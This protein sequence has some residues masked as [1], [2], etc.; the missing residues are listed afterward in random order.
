M[1]RFTRNL[2]KYP[3]ALRD[4][5]HNAKSKYNL[6]SFPTSRYIPAHERKSR[7]EDVGITTGDFVYISKGEYKGQV[8]SVISYADQSGCFLTHDIKA[9]RIIPRDN[10]VENQTSHLLE[11]PVEIP[12]EDVKLVAKDKDEKGNVSFVVADEIVQRDR[13]YDDRYKRWMPRRF[14][15]H[16]DNIEIPWPKPDDSYDKSPVTASERAAHFKSY[17]L[18]TIGKPPFPSAVLRQLR[19]PYSSHKKRT[20]S[21]YEARKLNEPQ[22]PLTTEQ[23]IYLAKKAQTPQKKLRP[24]SEEVKDFI[25]QKMANHLSGINDPY[26]LAHLDSLSKT[27]SPDFE[28]TMEKINQNDHPSQP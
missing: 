20:L 16:H 8:T 22:M 10:W 3:K 5:L 24:L 19:N 13:Y 1:T 2:D 14:V 28:S 12:E 15:K 17:E 25:G 18:Q 6:P 26:L 9:K 7:V 4:L 27:R 23:K 21:E 11:L